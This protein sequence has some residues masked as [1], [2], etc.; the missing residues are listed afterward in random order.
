[1][2]GRSRGKTNSSCHLGKSKRQWMPSS[3]CLSRLFL[4]RWPSPV[5]PRHRVSGCEQV[6]GVQHPCFSLE[7]T[8]LAGI[9]EE[10][11][12][13]KLKYICVA[14]EIDPDECMPRLHVQIILEKAVSLYSPFLVKH[15][16][17]PLF[18]SL[19]SMDLSMK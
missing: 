17:M 7:H 1:M 11:R 9:K 10:L 14:N 18:E 15:T 4:E 8:V 13:R 16:G 12:S 3:A 19:H 5:G 2:R 6:S